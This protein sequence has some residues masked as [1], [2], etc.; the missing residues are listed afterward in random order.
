MTVEE[1]ADYLRVPV[2]AVRAWRV[3]RIGPPGVRFG[4]YVRFRRRNVDA[5]ADEQSK[6]V[7]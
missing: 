6:A 2:S 7:A 5:W 4:K 3:K 1:V